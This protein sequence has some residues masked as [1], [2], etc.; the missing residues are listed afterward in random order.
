MKMLQ[1]LIAL[2]MLAERVWKH[3]MVVSFFQRPLPTP[4]TDPIL[5]SLIQPVLSGDPTMLACLERSLQ[6]KSRYRLEYIWLADIDD[7][8]GQRICQ[9]LM[10]R[11]PERR[12][13]LIALPPPLEGQNPKTVKLIAGAKAARG[14]VLC[15][16][17]DDTMLPDDGLERCLPFLDQPGVGL[18]FGLPYY[19]NFSN[20]WSSMVSSFVNSN[21]LL[22]YIPYTVLTEPF[23]INGMFYAIRRELLA[24]VGGF[25]AIEYIFADDFAIAQLICSHGYRLAQTPLCHGI[26]TQVKGPRHYLSLIQRWFVLPRES[27]LRHLSMRDRLV[28]YALGLV[29]ALFPLLLMAYLLLRPSRRTLAY[30]LLYFGYSFAIFAH[31]NRQYLREASPWRM[32]WWVPIIQVVFPFQLLVALLS[33]QRINWRGNIV[34]VKR[35]GSFR[36]VRRRTE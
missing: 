15:V 30:T 27:L 5:V 11:Y 28:V 32:A 29:P 8:A 24:A 18:A 26:S 2:L 23:T 4:A 17:D 16:L 33:P 31:F 36:Y 9:Q 14:E 22:T 20:I 21:S 25:E 1:R 3:W 13:Q 10:M 6:L 12:V 19:V 34:Q 35:G 7:L